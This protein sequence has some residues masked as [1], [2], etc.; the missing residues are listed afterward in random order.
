MIHDDLKDVL[1]IDDEG[2]ICRIPNIPMK[3]KSKFEEF[4]HILITNENLTID[5]ADNTW[6]KTWL[7]S[8]FYD[9][10]D[11]DETRYECICSKKIKHIYYICNKS[12]NNIYQVGCDCVEKHISEILAKNL[13]LEKATEKK[14]IKYE[15]KKEE[16]IKEEISV[17]EMRIRSFKIQM[18][19]Y[20]IKLQEFIDNY[21]IW[22]AKE[23]TIKQIIDGD[24]DHKDVW[25]NLDVIREWNREIK[26]IYV[27]P[28]IKD[29]MDSNFLTTQQY[30]TNI[31]VESL[32][33]EIPSCK[34]G[35]M[36]ISKKNP[37]RD[38][39]FCMNYDNDRNCKTYG[40]YGYI[41]HNN[42][43][44]NIHPL[45]HLQRQINKCKNE[46]E[47]LKNNLTF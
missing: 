4:K 27:Y 2:A 47:I 28:E 12:S 39:Y 19:E 37:E 14:R 13:K 8:G 43:P 26:Y 11:D 38:S 6:D 15:K 34:C 46:I 5:N 31:D 36:K 21:I 42:I 10:D 35:K 18:K 1:Y 17:Y 25:R 29:F 22:K 40:I 23:Y 16:E 20:K 41:N 7:S 33:I 30:I 45:T 24:V 3:S 44:T 9:V 32:N